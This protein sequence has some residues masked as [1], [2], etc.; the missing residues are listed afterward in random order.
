MGLQC[1]DHEIGIKSIVHSGPFHLDH[2]RNQMEGAL[3]NN[4]GIRY[5]KFITQAF[6]TSFAY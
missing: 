5:G 4:I 2:H 6:K 3:N 1:H